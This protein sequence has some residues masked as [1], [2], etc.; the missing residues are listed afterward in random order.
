MKG[1]G[2]FS[3]GTTVHM[4]NIFIFPDYE[5]LIQPQTI[6]D[7]HRML[8]QVGVGGQLS[9]TF[10]VEEP[11]LDIRFRL[12]KR[13]R[14]KTAGGM[15]VSAPPPNLVHLTRILSCFLAFLLS[16]FLAFLVL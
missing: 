13:C 5:N 2:F 8:N 6:F 7:M 3:H 9:W 15:R 1:G 11:G 4:A 12:Q 16:C 14:A 10:Q